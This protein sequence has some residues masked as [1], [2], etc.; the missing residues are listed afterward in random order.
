MR[1]PFKTLAGG[2]AAL[3]MLLP[4]AG[5]AQSA[6]ERLR[7]QLRATTQQ[8]QD[9]QNQYAQAAAAKA[10]AEAAR[11]TAQ[12]QLAAARG[13]AEGLRKRATRLEGDQ[14]RIRRQQHEQL[15]RQQ[16]HQAAN[17]ALQ[18]QSAALQTE[19]T[20]LKARLDTRDGEYQSCVAKNREMY[21]A[22][23]ELLSAYEAFGAGSLL[24]VRQPFAGRA[25]VLFDD[26]A[27]AFGDRLYQSQ[28]GAASPQKPVQGQ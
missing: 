3:L 23:R 7:A 11:D 16:E 17:Q 26:T 18:Q 24:A 22:G 6:E 4:V 28:V 25:R 15:A 2:M 5:Q 27:Q 14:E 12:Q 13:E 9:A 10:A 1:Q 20:A 19:F 21:Q 8:L